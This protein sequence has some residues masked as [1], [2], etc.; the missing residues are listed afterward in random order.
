MKPLQRAA[1]IEGMESRG[2][3][4]RKRLKDVAIPRS[5]YYAWKALTCGSVA[6]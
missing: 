4:R 2:T 1:L 5:T 6:S 3:G